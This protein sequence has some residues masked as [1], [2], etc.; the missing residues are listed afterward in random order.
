MSARAVFRSTVGKSDDRFNKRI[1][2]FP[3]L[4]AW[5]NFLIFQT[6]R[7]CFWTTS[8][9]FIHQNMYKFSQ[10]YGNGC[11]FTPDCA[12]Y[13]IKTSV[14]W[15]KVR[16]M[17]LPRILLSLFCYILQ[18]EPLIVLDSSWPNSIINYIILILI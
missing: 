4:R 7:K 9:Y 13:F 8:S 12:E 15:E 6:F 11:W 17:S 5:G 2:I 16:I 1:M 10:K 18:L 3:H 14:R